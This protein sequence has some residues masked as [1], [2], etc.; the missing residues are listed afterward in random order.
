MAMKEVSMRTALTLGPADHGRV[1]ALD[2]FLASRG[3]EGYR[4]EL[5][6]GRVHVSPQPSLPH[7]CVLEWLHLRMSDYARL[8]PEVLNYLS[9][10]ARVFVPDADEV[11]APE[12]DFTG[13]QGFPLHLPIRLRRWQD[14][15]PILVAEIVSAD[16]PD[17]D[18][19]RNVELYEGVASI[20]EYWILDPRTDADNPTLRVYRRRGSRWQ[21]PIDVASGETYTT[22]LLPDFSLTLD[23]NA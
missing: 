14:V 18:L 8:R 16:D 23:P 4:Y 17:K 6:R 1:L 19:V 22:R 11:T 2:E 21:R 13:Y 15:S 9:L 5:I 12:P 3:V 7:D 20:R 10:N